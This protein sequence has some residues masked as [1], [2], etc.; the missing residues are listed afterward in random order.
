MKNIWKSSENVSLEIIKNS[1]KENVTRFVLKQN[2]E[3]KNTFLFSSCGYRE[4]EGTQVLLV[5]V[6]QYDKEGHTKTLNEFYCFGIDLNGKVYSDI[7]RDGWHCGV[8][9]LEVNEMEGEE[10]FVEN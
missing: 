4:V 10:L 8:G 7:P 6:G 9:K 1:F 5:T 2:G 3:V